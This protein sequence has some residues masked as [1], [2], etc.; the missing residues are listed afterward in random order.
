MIFQ[1][2][3]VFFQIS[4]NRPEASPPPAAVRFSANGS[5][6]AKN[7]TAVFT[8]A[9]SYTFRVSVRNRA[10]LAVNIARDFQV[11]PQMLLPDLRR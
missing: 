10:G 5:N 11:R 3:G 2:P 8:Q 4:V 7:A 1:P 9:G 6:A